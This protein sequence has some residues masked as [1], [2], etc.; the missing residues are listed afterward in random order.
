MEIDLHDDAKR[1]WGSLIELLQAERPRMQR[2]SQAE[3]LTPTDMGVLKLVYEANGPIAMQDLTC[4]HDKS[5]VT[6]TVHRLVE[7]G[8]VE[9]HENPADRRTKFVLATEEGR[10]CMRRMIDAFRI[11]PKALVDVAPEDL[12]HLGAVLERVVEAAKVRPSG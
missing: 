4:F 12:R 3:G 6:R 5:S 9:R 11:P 2:I 10:A 1:V 7:L 8:L